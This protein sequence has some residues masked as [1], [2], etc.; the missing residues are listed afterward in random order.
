[1]SGYVDIGDGGVPALSTEAKEKMRTPRGIIACVGF[2]MTLLG[3]IFQW[4][5][6]KEKWTNNGGANL[7]GIVNS[8]G[9]YTLFLLCAAGA[10]VFSYLY[11]RP[12]LM[13][14]SMTIMISILDVNVC[15]VDA[16]RKDRGGDSW[17]LI[18]AFALCITGT[19]LSFV[20]FPVQDKMAKGAHFHFIFVLFMAVGSILIW[21]A[22]NSCPNTGLW[23]ASDPSSGNQVREAFSVTNAIIIAVIYLVSTVTSYIPG[24]ELSFMLGVM[25]IATYAPFGWRCT[26]GTCQAGLVLLF[27]NFIA[28]SLYHLVFSCPRGPTNSGGLVQKFW[29]IA[30]CVVGTVVGAIMVWADNT[31]G[32]KTLEAQQGW[33]VASM[34]I[35]ALLNL[36]AYYFNHRG[37]AVAAFSMMFSVIVQN[38]G[39]GIVGTDDGG[40]S[41]VRTGYIL[42]FLFSFLSFAA[43]P[44]DWKAG[45]S[46]GRL[47]AET[48]Q[49]FM[50]AAVLFFTVVY[51]WS[52][53]QYEA[54]LGFIGLV[55]MLCL[56]K[57]FHFGLQWAYVVSIL[58]LPRLTPFTA[59]LVPFGTLYSG[60]NK[61][62]IFV[63]LI[64]LVAYVR[65]HISKFGAVAFNEVRLFDLDGASPSPPFSHWQSK[66]EGSSSAQTPFLSQ[67]APGQ[68]SYGASQK[69]C[70]R[71][72]LLT[73]QMKPRNGWT[74]WLG[75][76][77]GTAVH[78]ISSQLLFF[79]EDKVRR[80][81][82]RWNYHGGVITEI[83]IRKLHESS[84][85]GKQ[86]QNIKGSLFLIFIKMHSKPLRM[87]I[88]RTLCPLPRTRTQMSRT[89]GTA[90]WLKQSRKPK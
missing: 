67:D 40:R 62:L 8:Y 11:N 58:S 77:P 54:G 30:V 89:G 80:G 56:A 87:R 33:W 32:T 49:A 59:A 73:Y 55:V 27:I 46:L 36:G 10:N 13:W 47:D 35:V 15:V 7:Q 45:I 48:Q 53:K 42:L 75:V 2:A 23:T 14:F 52:E 28:M 5:Q 83:Q 41:V 34:V 6:T 68:T 74:A 37:C 25:A 76:H 18:F 79:C 12:E 66:G 88:S 44:F 26:D 50:A 90:Q 39:Q 78:Y 57:E 65:F 24:L 4:T 21:A 60:T 72:F 84:F 64:C 9:M 63:C 31:G 22:G 85:E 51:L 69:V 19:F 29:F 82:A 38:S 43:M 70:I 71:D 3:L 20:T 17:F 81:M 1:M 16:I 86:K 61:L